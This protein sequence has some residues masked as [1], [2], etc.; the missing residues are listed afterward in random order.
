MSNLITLYVRE[1]MLRGASHDTS[2]L[3]DQNTMHLLFRRYYML[4]HFDL[5]V[6]LIAYLLVSDLCLKLILEEWKVTLAQFA[7]TFLSLTAKS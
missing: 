5:S 2:K 1:I 4:Q 6:P 3:V 7:M